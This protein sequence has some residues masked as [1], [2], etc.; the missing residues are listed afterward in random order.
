MKQTAILLKNSWIFL[1]AV[2]SAFVGNAQFNLTT[3]YTTFP[4]NAGGYPN[5]GNGTVLVR[6]APAGTGVVNTIRTNITNSG[7]NNNI[8]TELLNSRLVNDF[9][10]KHIAQMTAVKN[11]TAALKNRRATYTGGGIVISN[12]QQLNANR[13]LLSNNSTRTFIFRGSINV[14]QVIS[15]GSNKTIWIDGEVRYVGATIPNTGVSQFTPAGEKEDGLF[16]LLGGS[17]EVKNTKFFGTKRGRIWTGNK[18]PAIYISK[19]RNITVKDIEFYNCY[20]SISFKNV[21]G[22]SNYIQNNFFGYGQRRSI[23]LK[24]SNQVQVANNFIYRAGQD[25]VDVDAF[26]Q[27]CQIR[28]NVILAGGDRFQIWIEIGSSGNQVVDNVGIHTPV[29]TQSNGGMQENG[30][31]V[32]QAPTKNNSWTRNHIFYAQDFFQGI[33]MSSSRVINRNSISF[34]NNY[35]WSLKSSATRH[36]PK[37]QN[38]IMGDVRYLTRDNPVNGSARITN[39]TTVVEQEANEVQQLIVGTYPNPLK[40]SHLNVSF[41]LKEK[42]DVLVSVFDLTGK[43]LYQ[44]EEKSLAQGDHLL[45]IENALLANASDVVLLTVRGNGIQQTHKIALQ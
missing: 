40:G 19:G 27:N 13:A 11:T 3:G 10:N 16:R 33:T 37:P 18:A 31:E 45:L 21:Y 39:E 8:K 25:G 17:G 15:V 22:Q 20:N 14:S 4:A 2:L 30:S 5:L 32:G 12:N 38:G 1:F 7:L 29:R 28:Q 42:T 26:S 34:S 36:N 6:K 35:V 41:D 44:R 9:F 24:A 23:H 43:V